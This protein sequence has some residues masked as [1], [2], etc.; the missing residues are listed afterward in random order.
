MA[1]EWTEAERKAM[2]ERMKAKHAEKAAAP[3]EAVDPPAVEAE[4]IV[5]AMPLVEGEEAFAPEPEPAVLAP[6]T[7]FD[8]Y[9]STLTDETRDLLT[10]DELRK[11]FEDGELEAREEKRKKLR[12]QARDRALAAARATEGLIPAEKIEQ[13]ATAEKMN[14][15]VKVR[16][17][18]P[19]VSDS[20][21]VSAAGVTLDGMTYY[22]DQEYVMPMGRALTIRDIL[23]RLHQNELDF[24]GKGRLHG[25]RRQHASTVN[26]VRM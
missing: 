10:E 21:G 4:E 7:P 14:K 5:E 24:E 23:Y 2:S 22:H 8:I 19:F 26:M 17:Q 11:A 18:L 9:L 1:K 25:L 20:G 13:M 12:Q 6:M 3:A 15:K 16:I